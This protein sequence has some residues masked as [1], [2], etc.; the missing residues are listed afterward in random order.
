MRRFGTIAFV[1]TLIMPAT[2]VEAQ[3]SVPPLGQLPVFVQ[4]VAI[5]ATKL[6][7]FQ[8][9]VDSV[10]TLGYEVLGT[11]GGG[12]ISVDVREVRDS[13]GHSARGLTVD[14]RESQTRHE[15]S[16]VDA[17]EIPALLKGLDA[18]LDAIV[19]PTA[20]KRFEVTYTTRGSLVLLAYSNASGVL[21]YSVQAGRTVPSTVSRL[22]A[23]ELH[24]LRAIFD[25]AH[26]K[27]IDIAQPLPGSGGER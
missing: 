24:A 17:D 1:V 27:L 25:A 12:R 9:A 15:R 23:A 16:Y 7:G 8:P 19:N 18:L 26:R 22:G 4:P 2:A 11:V 14:V 5:P 13:A 6:D 21:E 20:F 10:V 3:V